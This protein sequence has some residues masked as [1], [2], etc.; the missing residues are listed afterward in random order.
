MCHHLSPDSSTLFTK[1]DIAVDAAAAKAHRSRRQAR[2]KRADF[3]QSYASITEAQSAHFCDLGLDD[4][5]AE[6]DLAELAESIM[7]SGRD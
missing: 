2:L 7:S 4:E 3:G 5:G 1:R 6:L